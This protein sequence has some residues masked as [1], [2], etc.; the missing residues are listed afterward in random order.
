[1]KS[2]RIHANTTYPRRRIPYVYLKYMQASLPFQFNLVYTAF[3]FPAAAAG[4]PAAAAAA[5]AAYAAGRGFSA[6]AAAGYP[7]FGMT[8]ATA[9]S[10]TA[11][12]HA[13]PGTSR[14]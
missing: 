3:L 4:I 9:A 13:P 14:N 2:A 7:G 8:P 10:I 5:Y 1:M 6:A 11:G 12:Y